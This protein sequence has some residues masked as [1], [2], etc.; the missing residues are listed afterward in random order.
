MNSTLETQH[1]LGWMVD[2]IDLKHLPLVDLFELRQQYPYSIE[3]AP[4]RASARIVG[5]I[6]GTIEL[7]LMSLGITWATLPDG[8]IC[9]T[10]ITPKNEREKNAMAS[11]AEGAC[12]HAAFITSLIEAT[13]GGDDHQGHASKLGAL[14][15][16]SKNV[17]AGM[18]GVPAHTE[19]DD[20]DVSGI[21]GLPW[22]RCLGWNTVEDW[23][24]RPPWWQA[25][26]YES[27]DEAVADREG[28]D[29]EMSR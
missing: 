19:A 27:E 16:A 26:G 28:R 24:S 5:L 1:A 8:D 23:L 9:F 13:G 10:F 21:N 15:D 4:T 11:L 17:Y 29:K 12:I 22:W 18:Y 3:N 14:V 25:E 6:D 2:P 7:A 20:D